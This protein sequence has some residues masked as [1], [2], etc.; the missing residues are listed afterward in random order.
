MDSIDLLPLQAIAL[1]KDEFMRT[2]YSMKDN[3]SYIIMRDSAEGEYRVPLRYG[4]T[5]ED[6]ENDIL[7]EWRHDRNSVTEV[8]DHD[9]KLYLK[10]FLPNADGMPFRHHIILVVF[11][12]NLNLI[13][14]MKLPADTV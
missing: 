9:G 11:S 13:I 6:N 7:V 1:A 14:I 10:D 2:E 5:Y 8:W 12:T 3:E 4:S